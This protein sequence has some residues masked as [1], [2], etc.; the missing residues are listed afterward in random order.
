MLPE[1]HIWVFNSGDRGF[2]GGL[3]SDRTQ[4]EMWIAQY[5]LTGVLTAY[6]LDEGCYDFAVRNGFLS[7]RALEQN[8]KITRIPILL[9]HSPRLLLIITIS[10]TEIA[11]RD[12]RPDKVFSMHLSTNFDRCAPIS[13][14]TNS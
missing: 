2:P 1:K 12:D 14:K 6:P 5:R 11:F 9:D 13:M 3:F 8:N 4:A 10:R 7:Q